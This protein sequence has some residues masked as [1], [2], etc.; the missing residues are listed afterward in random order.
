MSMSVSS[1]RGRAISSFIGRLSV[2]AARMKSTA[3]ASAL[4]LARQAIAPAVNSSAYST[5][6]SA[7]RFAGGS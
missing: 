4:S 7:S 5:T 3:T 6:P 1:G 2:R